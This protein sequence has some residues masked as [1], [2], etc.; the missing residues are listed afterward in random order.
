[1][2]NLSRNQKTLQAFL[3]SSRY[4]KT[5][6]NSACRRNRDA[7]VASSNNTAKHGHLLTKTASFVCINQLLQNQNLKLANYKEVF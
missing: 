4:I 2:K 7:S 1:M 5:L 6:R 3:Y